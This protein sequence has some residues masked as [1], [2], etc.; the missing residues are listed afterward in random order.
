MAC[1]PP[2]RFFLPLVIAGSALLLLAENH[3][4]GQG[5]PRCKTSR[6]GC[7]C[8]G[9]RAY[10]EAVEGGVPGMGEATLPGQPGQTSSA[11]P[12]S[13]SS[14]LASNVGA[15]AGAAGAIP[16]MIG[17]FFGNNYKY[18]FTNPDGTTV[19]TAGGQRRFKYAENTNPFPTDR[20]F[21]NYHFF[22]DPLLD[23]NGHPRD[24][25]LF[26]FGLEKTF[27]D[28]IFSVE[29]RVPFSAA[30][31]SDQSFSDPN[32]MATEFGNISLAAKV[33]LFQSDRTAVATGLGIVF[34]TGDDSVVID[35]EST[36]LIFENSSLYLQP[37]IGIYN[38]P[39]ERLFHQFL[40]QVD[41]DANGSDVIIPA[42]SFLARSEWDQSEIPIES[43]TEISRLQ[44]Q[45]LLYLDYQVGFWLYRNPCASVL[46]AV[47]PL[48]ELHYTSTLQNLDLGGFGEDQRGPAPGIFVEDLRRDVLNLTSGAYFE[49][50]ER[51]SVKVA[52]V[53]P[54]LE[55]RVFD[56]ELG[57]QIN[58]RY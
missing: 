4:L 11:A 12:Y 43:E 19:A 15:T 28:E 1:Y 30:L 27:F 25:S 8:L 20:V 55:D 37:F 33:L 42:D 38:A 9:C 52:A 35:D 13:E 2:L 32:Q 17:D 24:L 41:F 34:P 10:F 48:L 54:L 46:T 49:L 5:L 26:T 14:L 47:A 58:H 3:A 6:F 57:L 56:Y 21:F 50:F 16:S 36:A 7:N 29:F 53:A 23:M 51:T 18:A 44:S 39:T 31:D 40:A 22:E 45:T